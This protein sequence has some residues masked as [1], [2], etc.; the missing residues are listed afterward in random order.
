MLEKSKK[1]KEP[2][3]I[4][5]RINNQMVNYKVYYLKPTEKI[6]YFLVSF[7]VGGM[8]GLVFYANLFMV[9][10]KATIATYISNTAVFT[11]VGVFAARLFMSMRADTICK[12]R[13]DVLR[14]QFRE[15]LSS[16]NSSFA[17]GANVVMAFQNAQDDMRSQYGEKA[18]ITIEARE[19]IEQ[20]NNNISV[21]EALQDFASRTG[22]EDI[23]DFT[24]VF[25]ICYKKCKN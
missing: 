1:G 2:Q 8:I 6:I 15:Y 7:V 10:G 17:T 3:Y 18:Y 20:I 25:D 14:K 5:S 23:E 4:A 19:I 12:K 22:I 21:Y 13:Q 11:A 9:D 16:L 24:T